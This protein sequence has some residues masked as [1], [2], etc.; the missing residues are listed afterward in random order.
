MPCG[1]DADTIAMEKKQFPSIHELMTGKFLRHSQEFYYW[2]VK[3][4][5]EKLES[6]PDS[7]S[8]YDDIS[9]A[10]DKIGEHEKAIQAM[11]DKEKI[12][13]GLYETYANLGTFYIHNGDYE[14]GLEKI[15]KAIEINPEAHFGREVYQQYVVEYVLKRIEENGELKL[16][17]AKSKSNNF[18]TFLKKRHFKSAIAAGSNEA[19][20][21]AKAIKGIAGMMRFGFYNSPVLLEA[22]GDLLNNVESGAYKNAGHLASRVYLKASLDHADEGVKKAYKKLAHDSREDQFGPDFIGNSNTINRHSAGGSAYRMEDLVSVLKLEVQAGEAW[23]NQI[24]R[25]EMGW[26]A[27]GINP[28]SA[29]TAKYYEEPEADAV[30]YRSSRKMQDAIDE[31]RWVTPQL[32]EPFEAPAFAKLNDSI[33]HLIDSFY[34]LEF[35]APEP[36]AEPMDTV[37]AADANAGKGE[38]GQEEGPSKML[39]FAALVVVIGGYLIYRDYKNGKR[40][41]ED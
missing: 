34:Q 33:T 18:Y 10:Y 3:D 36:V 15:K 2:R 23:F 24:R 29:F 20:E 16:P 28:D 31:I 13:P 1:W 6:H 21:M 27:A 4:R 32:S 35:A 9:V 11:L 22:M 7:L 40:I 19:D 12:A 8:L 38:S 25:D 26:I 37:Q 14:L 39:I 5:A 17:M 30:G 41:S